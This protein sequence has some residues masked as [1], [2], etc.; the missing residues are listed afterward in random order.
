MRWAEKCVCVA[1]RGSCAQVERWASERKCL[2]RWVG[3]RAM[4]EWMGKGLEILFGEVE[5]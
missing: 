3:G 5:R 4:W 2:V 1:G